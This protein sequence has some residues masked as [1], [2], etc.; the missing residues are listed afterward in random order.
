MI[1]AYRGE[2]PRVAASAFVASTAVVVGDVEIGPDASLWFHV[3]VR[4][5]VNPIRIGASTNVQDG[6]VVHATPGRPPTLLES[7][8]TVGHQAI[9]H[10]C[11]VGRRS[12]VGMGAMLLDGCRVGEESIV[13]AGALVPPE[14]VVPPRS[15]VKGRPARFSRRVTDEDVEWILE[16]AREYL[17]LKRQYLADGLGQTP[18]RS[19]P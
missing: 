3:V 8:V 4:G 13:A 15:L 12:L 14:A 18:P 2:S 19:Q 11:H 1:R 10:G 6:T 5:D 9:L 17:E 7:W 16:H